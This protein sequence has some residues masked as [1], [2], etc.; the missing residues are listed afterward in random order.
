MAAPCTPEDA[1][2]DALH[3][4]Y[5]VCHSLARRSG[6]SFY[7]SFFLLPRK[8]RLAMCALY[9]FFRL[10]DDISDE[11][12]EV[13]AKGKAICDFRRQLDQMTR[14]K[15]EHP[16]FPALADTVERYNI[17][18]ELLQ[19]TLEGVEM[20]LTKSRY[21][22]FEELET[23]CYRVASAVGIACVHVWGFTSDAA[24]KPAKDCGL[25]FQLT[26][27]LR[28]LREDAQRDR[29]YLPTED[30]AQFGYPEASLLRQEQHA[31]FDAFMR[32]E[33]DRA[34]RY[35]QSSRDLY[36]WLEPDGRKVFGAMWSTYHELLLEIKRDPSQ[37]L[38]RR[39]SLSKWQKLRIVLQST[40]LPRQSWG[41]KPTLQA[42][43]S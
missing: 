36:S 17:P 32:F 30:F 23:Y 7:L 4:S 22:S 27:I 33:I 12:G 19:A 10:A 11:P 6:S 20:D 28:D 21:V 43:S 42:K 41:T 14:G 24:L 34:T 8:K 31:S 5:R 9:A 16:V 25:A 13:G 18:L 26:N 2:K 38:Q 40:F 35:F 3:E 1:M 29:I 37:V 15:F 39:I